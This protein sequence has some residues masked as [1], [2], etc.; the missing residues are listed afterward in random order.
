M[1][2]MFGEAKVF[3]RNLSSWCVPNIKSEPGDFSTNSALTSQN[4]PKW[5]TCP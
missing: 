3:N 4:K 2:V 5:G 1:N